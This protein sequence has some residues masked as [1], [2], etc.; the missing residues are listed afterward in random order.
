LLAVACMVLARRLV[1]TEENAHAYPEPEHPE[2][3]QAIDRIVDESGSRFTRKK[4]VLLAGSGALGTL[5]LAAL[6]PAASLGPALDTEQLD[7]TPWRRGRRLVDEAGKPIA[8]ADIEEE[9]F[10]TAY[11]EGASRELLGSPLVVVRLPA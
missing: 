5:G 10:Y 9:S 4:L 2:D 1:V 6:T 11:P 7:R 8:A 3:Q